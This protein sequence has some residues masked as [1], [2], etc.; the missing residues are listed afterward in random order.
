MSE[1]VASTVAGF[2]SES[3]VPE[4]GRLDYD[5]WTLRIAL[6]FTGSPPAYLTFKDLSGFR[7]LREGDLI[8]YWG[9]TR[10]S[11]WLWEIQSGGWRSTE[12]QRSGFISGDVQGIREF[13]VVSLVDCVSV[14]SSS[15]PEF[16]RIEP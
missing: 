8:E 13:L 1:F 14:L 7:V 10:P 6:H 9:P 11:G 2:P 12:A 3:E 16:S 15:A 5:I 4:I